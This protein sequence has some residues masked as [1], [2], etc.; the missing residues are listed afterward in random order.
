MRK[1]LGIVL[2][3]GVLALALAAAVSPAL[4]WASTPAAAAPQAIHYKPH[5]AD[6]PTVRD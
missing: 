1:N 5:P 3:A 2:S 6:P 4:A